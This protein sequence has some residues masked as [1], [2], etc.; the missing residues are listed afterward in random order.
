MH[1]LCQLLKFGIIP[2]YIYV[3]FDKNPCGIVLASIN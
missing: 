3:K 1:A 2:I